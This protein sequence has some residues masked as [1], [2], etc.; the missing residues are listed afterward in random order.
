MKWSKASNAKLIFLGSISGARILELPAMAGA[1]PPSRP[2][3][4]HRRRYSP[5]ILF[6]RGKIVH[7][8]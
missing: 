1:L 8:A 7:G 2:A 6:T 3:A 4:R 5:T